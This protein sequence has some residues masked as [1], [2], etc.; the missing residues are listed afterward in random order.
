[1]HRVQPPLLERRLPARFALVVPPLAARLDVLHPEWLTQLFTHLKP[2]EVLLLDE[3]QRGV[4]AFSEDGHF[5][6]RLILRARPSA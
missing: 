1:M 3:D 6:L 2:F 4:L 5:R